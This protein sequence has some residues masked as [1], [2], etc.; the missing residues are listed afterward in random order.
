MEKLLHCL[1][2]RREDKNV[3]IHEELDE[4]NEVIFFENGTVDVGFDLN[5]IKTYVI[6]IES[7]ILIGGYNVT[8]GKRTKFVYKTAQIC[9]GFSIR[10]A[11]WKKIVFNEEFSM[12]TVHLH[13]ALKNNYE[14]NILSKVNFE[15]QKMIEKWKKRKDYDSI[16]RVVPN[17]I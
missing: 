9:S 12:I 6:R 2:P 11:N 14:N 17:K 4:V 7:D 5:R 13:N 10:R 16:L 15:K 3:I 8:F 1:E